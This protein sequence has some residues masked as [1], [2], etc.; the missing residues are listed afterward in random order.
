MTRAEC[1]RDWWPLLKAAVY[2]YD[3]EHVAH[4][5]TVVAI[6]LDGCDQEAAA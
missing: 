1:L 4:I 6:D 2:C 3:A 5:L